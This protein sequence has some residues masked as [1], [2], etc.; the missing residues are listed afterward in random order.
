MR[1]LRQIFSSPRSLRHLTIL[2]GTGAPPRLPP[3]TPYF[4][5]LTSLTLDSCPLALSFLSSALPTI[6]HVELVRPVDAADVA[7]SPQIVEAV[8]RLPKLEELRIPRNT[9]WTG[10]GVGIGVRC[11]EKGVELVWEEGSGEWA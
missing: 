8:L 5:S 7:R 10:E 9:F 2:G 6:T 1:R 3:S 11:V 4:P